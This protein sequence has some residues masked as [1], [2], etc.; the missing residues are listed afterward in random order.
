MDAMLCSVSAVPLE[1]EASR[2]RSLRV[3]LGVVAMAKV[4]EY[5]VPEKCRK[6]VGRSVPPVQ[7]GKLIP[8]PVGEQK[9]A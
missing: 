2:S 8:F 4:I 7:C 3:R 1:S 9:P 5:Y 6:N